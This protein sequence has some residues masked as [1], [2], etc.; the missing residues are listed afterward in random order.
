MAQDL[1]AAYGLDTPD[2]NIALYRD[3]AQTYDAAFAEDMDYVLPMHVAQAYRDGGG[4]GPVIDLGAG[5]GL[6]GAALRTLGIAPVTATDL[7]QEMLSVA[8]GKGIYDR[9]FT[10]NLLERLP[11][12]DGA[13]AGAVSSGTFTHGHVG[14]E[15]LPE[16]LRVIR[17]GSIAV[18]S[19]NAAHW[20]DKG[21]D[22]A[23]SALAGTAEA[24][25]TEV[26]IYGASAKGEHAKDL[27][28]ILTL[29]RIP[30]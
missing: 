16:V 28:R 19:V 22:A 8:E 21:Y 1:E 18:L 25:W 20:V 27:S 23:I 7:S 9:I 11:V 15:A 14:P 5:T 2:D 3:W 4:T 6:C 24:S 17:P 13:F 26:P 30:V 12:D 10:G 29:K